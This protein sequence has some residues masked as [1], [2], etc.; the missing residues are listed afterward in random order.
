MPSGKKD[1]KSWFEWVSQKWC[2]GCSRTPV[3]VAHVKLFVS[4]KTAQLLPRRV[5]LNEWAVIPLCVECHRS[6]KNS[7]HNVGEFRWF[8]RMGWTQEVLLRTWSSW[9][10][11]WL[12]EK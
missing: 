7:I 8:E 3:E 12:T 10:V 4:P 2:L 5:G 6:G 1:L 9:F 11:E